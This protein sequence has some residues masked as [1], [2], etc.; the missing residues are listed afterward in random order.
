MNVITYDPSITSASSQFPEVNPYNGE[1]FYEK[2][3]SI[4]DDP[5]AIDQLMGELKGNINRD[6]CSTIYKAIQMYNFVVLGILLQSDYN[7]DSKF[8]R[9]DRPIIF[10][11][12]FG[13]VQ[14]VEM[15]IQAGACIKCK[16]QKGFILRDYIHDWVGEDKKRVLRLLDLH[17]G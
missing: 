2:L 12:A 10:A 1:K 15:L 4:R 9:H 17:G 3:N 11:A 6:G 5:A 7:F 13:N 14:A 16:N 8:G